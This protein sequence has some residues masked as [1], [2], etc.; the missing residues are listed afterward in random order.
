MWQQGGEVDAAELHEAL[1]GKRLQ[2]QPWPWGAVSAL[3]RR[4]WIN[5]RA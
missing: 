3:Q 5:R 1:T 2:L 4:R